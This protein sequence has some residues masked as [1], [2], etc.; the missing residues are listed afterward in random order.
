[1]AG[2]ALNLVLAVWLSLGAML[3]GCPCCAAGA[4][5]S[6]PMA[7]C[8]QKAAP[9][10]CAVCRTQQPSLSRSERATPPSAA[11]RRAPAAPARPALTAHFLERQ[12]PRS[13]SPPG[14]ATTA[15]LRL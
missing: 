12:P 6:G 10:C 14:A 1:M 2:S 5:Q 8:S 9:D 13:A 15:P 11:P 4:T 7:G 3:A